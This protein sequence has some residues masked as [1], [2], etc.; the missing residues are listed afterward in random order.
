MAPAIAMAKDPPIFKPTGLASSK[1]S[2]LKEALEYRLFSLPA[3]VGRAANQRR[4]QGSRLELSLISDL[5]FS[6]TLQVRKWPIQADI[7]AK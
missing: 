3:S 4:Q 6:M 2:S 1:V 5:T 7:R